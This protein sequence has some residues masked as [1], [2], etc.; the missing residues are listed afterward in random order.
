LPDALLIRRAEGEA[1]AAY[2]QVWPDVPLTF[3]R[4]NAARIPDHRKTFGPRFSPLSTGQRNAVNPGNAL[5]NYLYSIA[6]WETRAA[7]VVA[8]LDP[9]IGLFHTDYQDRASL[10]LDVIEIPSCPSWPV[11]PPTASI[12]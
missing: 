7:C 12:R 6:E 4:R 3:I 2:W 5:L 9:D 8:G 11:S 1:T 10:T